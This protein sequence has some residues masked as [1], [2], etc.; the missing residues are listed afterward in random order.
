MATEGAGAGAGTAGTAAAAATG[1]RLMEGHKTKHEHAA[2]HAP[3]P[4][5]HSPRPAVC[6]RGR[7]RLLRAAR[8]WLARA[9]YAVH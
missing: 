7:A 8:R 6:C 9:R 3:Q 2:L 4:L 5:H 1:A